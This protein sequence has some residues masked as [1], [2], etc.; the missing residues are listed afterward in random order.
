MYNIALFDLDGTITRSDPG[1]TESVISALERMQIPVGDPALLKRF[2]GP[3]LYDSFREFYGLSE[4]DAV[5]AVAYYREAYTQKGIFNAPLYDGVKKLL[6]N[7]HAK[8]IILFLVTSKPDDMARRVIAYHGID[9]Y[10]EEVIAPG[11]NEKSP[12]KAQLIQRVIEYT[13]TEDLSSMVMIGDRKFD[14]NGAFDMGVDSIGVL[15]GYGSRREFEE[16]HATFIVET[17]EEIE[18]LIEG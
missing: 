8:G 11:R 14:T 17:P 4:E 15:Y 2:I 1:I 5:R 3:P 12:D 13:G 16:N 10:F 6:Q 18:K 9:E 7:L